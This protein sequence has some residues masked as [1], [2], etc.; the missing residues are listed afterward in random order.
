MPQPTPARPLRIYTGNPL[1]AVPAPENLF[2][3][4]EGASRQPRR[5]SPASKDGEADRPVWRQSTHTLYW[6]GQVVHHFKS[7]ATSIEPLLRRFQ[8]HRWPPML[9]AH[10]LNGTPLAVKQRLHDTIKNLNRIVL[11][12]FQFRKEGSGERIYWEALDDQP[13]CNP[14]ATPK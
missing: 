14:N 6:R 2:G 11:P 9:S 1:D 13:Q 7:G 8:K 3:G 12:Y 5:R 4:T 10:L